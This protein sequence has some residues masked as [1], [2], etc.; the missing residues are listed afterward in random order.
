MMTTPLLV[1]YERKHRHDVLSLLFYSRRTHTHLDWYKTGHW[2]DLQ[3]NMIQLAYDGKGKL[4][5]VLGLSAVLNEGCWLRLL[6]IAQGAD[7]R[8]ILTVLWQSLC[9]RFENAG[10]RTVAILVINNWLT[11]YLPLMDFRYIEDVVTMHRTGVDLPTAPTH[12]LL[13]RNG[14]SEDIADMMRVDHAAF[15]SPWQMTRADFFNS[16][17]QAASCTLAEYKGR[18]VGYEVSTRHHTSGHLAR[19]AVI[20]QLQGKRVGS[21]LLHNLLSKFNRRGV[22]S[23]TVN[24]QQSNIRSQRL[25]ARYG[26]RRNGFDIPIWQWGV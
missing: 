15:P 17:R 22:R 20:P 11:A 25:Y 16:Q 8:H 4:I 9:P 14:Y 6:A 24:T 10:V 18:V 26:F 7:I 3:G 12:P 5:G 21:V 13:L 2:L 19:L 1:D 23:M